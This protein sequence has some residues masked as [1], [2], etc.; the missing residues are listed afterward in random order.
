VSAKELKMHTVINILAIVGLVALVVAAFPIYFF[1]DEKRVQRRKK[2]APYYKEFSQIAKWTKDD[3]VLWGVED[4]SKKSLEFEI[5][6]FDR[7]GA[8]VTKFYGFDPENIPREIRPHHWYVRVWDR[9]VGRGDIDSQLFLCSFVEWQIRCS[10]RY[11]SNN[12]DIYHVELCDRIGI[13]KTI[14]VN[15]GEGINWIDLLQKIEA[16]VMHG[17]AVWHY[18]LLK[19]EEELKMLKPRDR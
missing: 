10:G 1:L 15:K 13:D 14:T 8:I 7:S 6:F 12:N 5:I 9:E 19:A 2:A 11:L 16:I 3:S 17:N 4:L 18:E